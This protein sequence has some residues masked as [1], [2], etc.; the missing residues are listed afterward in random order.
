MIIKFLRPSSREKMTFS[1]SSSS[2]WETLSFTP[3]SSSFVFVF[4][5]YPSS[6]GLTAG[7][8]SPLSLSL[9][10]PAK[11][12]DDIRKKVA[13]AAFV[14][15]QT[16]TS[17]RTHVRD[18]PQYLLT[19]IPPSAAQL[20]GMTKSVIPSPEFAKPHPIPSSPGFAKQI[21][22]GSIKQKDPST[23]CLRHSAQDDK[24]KMASSR[25]LTAGSIK[26]IP[27]FRFRPLG[28]GGQVT[29]Q[30]AQNDNQRRRALSHPCESRD[31]FRFLL[32]RCQLPLACAEIMRPP[33]QISGEQ[34]E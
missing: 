30:A 14:S 17:S 29:G 5:L 16:K 31:P 19:K 33:P 12:E 22:R 13:P 25:G 9:D 27:A 28:F 20:F 3:S 21:I 11:P 34:N 18:L 6:R 32:N 2:S 15:A 26:K 7:S 1:D 23:S 8:T 4:P 24:K 10:P